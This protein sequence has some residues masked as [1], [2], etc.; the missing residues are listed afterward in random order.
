MELNLSPFITYEHMSQ[1]DERYF[2]VFLS[3][4]IFGVLQEWIDN[5]KQETV[6]ELTDII[7]KITTNVLR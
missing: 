6:N 7:D 1:K 3:N 4:A 5:D 2:L